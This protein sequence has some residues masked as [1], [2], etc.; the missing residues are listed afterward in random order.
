MYSNL[1]E[2]LPADLVT[3]VTAMCGTRG[4]AWFEE[5]PE[6][7]ARIEDCWKI[8][9]RDPFPGI[10]YNF[11]A[12]AVMGDGVPVVLKIAP[13]FETTE[14]HGE[15]K[16]LRMRDGTGAVRLLKEDREL[17]AILIERAVPGKSLVE[18]FSHD[19]IG[20]ISPAIEVLK[21]ITMEPP[22]DLTDVPTLDGWFATFRDRFPGTGFPESEAVG[23][24]EM[25]EELTAK[26]NDLRYIH[27]D[28]HLGNIVNSDRTPFLAIDPKGV[29]GHVGYEAAVFLINLYR[30]QCERNGRVRLLLDNAVSLFADGLG[31]SQS[32]IRRWGFVHT[33]IGAWWNY[34]DMPELYHPQ[35]AIPDIWNV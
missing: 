17:R 5:L 18:L 25:Y 24:I 3:H 22:D 16:F 20:C 31:L 32:A 34:E 4:E 26:G 23:A 8:D 27:G 7:I 14:I 10:E 19:P 13:P 1:K 29:V 12:P 21:S 2:K 33:V 9:V 6:M 35:L 15:A 28:F 30:W 11:V